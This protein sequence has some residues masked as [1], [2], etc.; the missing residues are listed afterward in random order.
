MD[1]ALVLILPLL[2]R[3]EY[4]Q[5][6]VKR[7]QNK[8]TIFGS[9]HFGSRLDHIKSLLSSSLPCFSTNVFDEPG[10]LDLILFLGVVELLQGGHCWKY[11]LPAGVLASSLGT[12]RQITSS[13]AVG[14]RQITT[15]SLFVAIVSFWGPL[16][17]PVILIKFDLLLRHVFYL[18]LDS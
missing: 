2:G 14:A 1:V 7:V 5:A 11:L 9:S 12:K 8:K 15:A 17:P 16:E 4:L 3:C 13:I 6:C 10:A 18:H